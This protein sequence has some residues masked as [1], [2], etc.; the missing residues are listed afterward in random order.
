M[1]L[2]LLLIGGILYF[3]GS[4]Q[5]DKTEGSSA[6]GRVIRLIGIGLFTIGLILFVAGFMI[7]LS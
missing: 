6:G 7:G 5:K 3:V 2:V 1:D 4:R